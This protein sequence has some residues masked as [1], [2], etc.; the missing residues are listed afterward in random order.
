LHRVLKKGKDM[1]T[2]IL[3]GESKKI[4][5]TFRKWDCVEYLG[6]INQIYGMNLLQVL[7]GKDIKQVNLSTF[8]GTVLCNNSEINF[9]MGDLVTKETYDLMLNLPF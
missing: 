3:S 9:F 6:D 1:V 4:D 5:G 8:T 2:A 7:E